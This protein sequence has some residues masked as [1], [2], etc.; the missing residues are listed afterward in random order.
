MIVIDNKTWKIYATDKMK[1][2]YYYIK[3]STY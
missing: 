2:E 3:L 1:K